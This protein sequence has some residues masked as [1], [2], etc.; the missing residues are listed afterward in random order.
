[1]IGGGDSII[2]VGMD[3]QETYDHAMAMSEAFRA[4]ALRLAEEADVCTHPDGERAAPEGG[5]PE[6]CQ[7]CGRIFG[8]R[9]EAGS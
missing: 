8:R 4:L 3:L 1:M 2:R 5:A 7:A 6:F 9:K